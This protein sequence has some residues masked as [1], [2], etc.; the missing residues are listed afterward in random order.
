M[1]ETEQIVSCVRSEE[2]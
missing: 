2:R 1:S